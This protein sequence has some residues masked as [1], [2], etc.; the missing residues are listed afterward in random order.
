MPRAY[1]VLTP[2]TDGSED[3]AKEIIEWLN[4]RVGPPKKL[5]GGVRFVKEVP[6]SPSG[7]LLRRLLRDQVKKEEGL[8]AMPKL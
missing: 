7:K 5:R 4:S 1:I 8:G 3:R 2:G 6:K